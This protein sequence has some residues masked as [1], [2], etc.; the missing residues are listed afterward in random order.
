MEALQ[1]LLKEKEAQLEATA[2][3]SNGVSME[4]I[5]IVEDII[6]LREKLGIKVE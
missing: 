2:E 4:M 5:Q 1:K 3:K 6:A